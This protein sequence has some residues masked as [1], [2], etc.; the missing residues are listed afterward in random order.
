MVGRKAR[1]ELE[2]GAQQEVPGRVLD[3]EFALAVTG[4]K[5]LGSKKSGAAP[6]P[7]VAKDRIGGGVAVA[8]GA[9]S[10]ERWMRA[11]RRLQLLDPFPKDFDFIDQLL[12]LRLRAG[13]PRR[14]QRERQNRRRRDPAPC[15]C[16]FI[17]LIGCLP[18]VIVR[19]VVKT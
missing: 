16:H 12:L 14:T 1:H 2:L 7:G 15:T 9:R 13:G 10:V 5:A 18:P 6:P 17:S 11:L 3:Q 8:A 4:G 19:A